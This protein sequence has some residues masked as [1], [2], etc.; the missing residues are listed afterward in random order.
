MATAKQFLV[1][2]KYKPDKTGHR[3]V[4]CHELVEHQKLRV[5]R[6]RHGISAIC[7]DK[8]FGLEAIEKFEVE[9]S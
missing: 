9:N 4:S 3:P 5:W 2:K 6:G 1:T 8:V 7:K